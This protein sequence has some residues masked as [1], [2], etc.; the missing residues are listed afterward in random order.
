MTD[1]T[2]NMKVCLLPG[3]ETLFKPKARQ[4]YCKYEHQLEH[5][6]IRH[7]IKQDKTK[8][9]LKKIKWHKSK[10][11]Q[12]IKFFDMFGKDFNCDLCQISFMDSVERDGIPLFV[13]LQ[14]GVDDYR[15]FDPN[16]WNR[17]CLQCYSSIVALK[18]EDVSEE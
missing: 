7:K 4:L 6:A 10:Y 9:E 2:G 1:S 13:K 17:F 12:L 3:C 5:Q 8:D 18:D 15:V 14:P 11:N 16:N